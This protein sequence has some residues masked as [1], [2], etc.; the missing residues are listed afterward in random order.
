MV[1]MG[2]L[3]VRIDET[4]EKNIRAEAVR[5]GISVSEYLRQIILRRGQPGEVKPVIDNMDAKKIIEAINRQKAESA[6]QYDKV[7]LLVKAVMSLNGNMQILDEV[8]LIKGLDNLLSKYKGS[9]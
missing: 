1:K 4:E 5:L 3:G 6:E 7:L 8:N 2:M 9:D